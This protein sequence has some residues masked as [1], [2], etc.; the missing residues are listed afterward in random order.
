MRYEAKTIDSE[1]LVQMRYEVKIIDSELLLEMYVIR[2]ENNRQWI[3]TPNICDT[4]WK[5]S[6]LRF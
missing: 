3:I 4:K 5:Q 2:S 1:L 6:I